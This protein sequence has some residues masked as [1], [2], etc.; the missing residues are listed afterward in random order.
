MC[1]RDSMKSDRAGAVTN[2]DAARMSAVPTVSRRMNDI[3]RL[4]P[5][6]ANIGSGFSVGGGNYRQSYVT[7]DGAAFNKDVYKRQT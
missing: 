7:V 3:M 1:I 5:Q 6:G 2:V 4:T